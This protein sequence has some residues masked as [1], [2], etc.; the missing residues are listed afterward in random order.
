M[1]PAQLPDID[2]AASLVVEYARRAV[3]KHGE[4]VAALL[5]PGEHERV[6]FETC[7]RP[8]I[9]TV[10]GREHGFAEIRTIDEYRARVPVR[11][12]DGLAP[13][14][15]RAAAGEPS[16]LTADPITAF[17]HTSGTTG[18][19]KKIP[20]TKRRHE[21]SDLVRRYAISAAMFEKV[22]ALAT[23]ADCAID[24]S[25]A[26]RARESTTSASI[27]VRSMTEHMSHVSE[28]LGGPGTVSPW[29]QLPSQVQTDQEKQYF[30]MRHGLEHDVRVMM[31]LN[32]STLVIAASV[33]A[34]EAPRLVAELRTGEVCGVPT[35]PPNPR[36]AD[37]LQALMARG[38]L[39]PADVWPALQELVCWKSA[40][41][42]LYL[43]R[44]R[45]LYG[46]G[47]RIRPFYISS[48]EGTI[49]LMVDDH[50]VA[51]PVALSIAF[52]EFVPADVEIT[53]HGPTLLPEQLID[54]GEYQVIMTQVNG[55]Y[56]YA[57]G[58]V[59][60]VNGFFGGV[61]RLEFIR[62]TGAVSSFTGE[63]LTEPQVIRAAEKALADRRR[64]Q[65]R[66][67]LRG[68]GRAPALHF[69]HRAEDGATSER[70]AAA[71]SRAR[72]AAAQ[73]QLRVSRQARLRPARRLRPRV[74]R[75]RH[76]APRPRAADRSR[77]LTR[78]TERPSA[79]PQPRRA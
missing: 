68:V 34:S 32:P 63:K 21:G 23:R 4:V 14:I 1:G 15:D 76:G 58:D 55:L 62:R 42:A 41:C 64:G 57:I 56:R 6:L 29:S 77:R 27:P 47:V 25:W 60:R 67:V 36:R 75:A 52:F 9:D 72:E 53:P 11:D 73:V 45:E 26:S 20:L 71:G 28:L 79:A 37:E 18:Q 12:Y 38:P 69:R 46:H 30:R 66:H 39:R 61:P 10:F 7:V 2:A 13:Y 49:T 78:P 43:P 8:N 48:S 50:E 17:F 35:L 31:A 40:A 24:F 65:L 59:V 51:G 54:G 44:L 19:S 3:A 5:R 70:G 22:P 74:C 33:L 16:V